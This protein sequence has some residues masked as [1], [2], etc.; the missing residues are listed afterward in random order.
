MP[1]E[2]IPAG[3]ILDFERSRV[4]AITGATPA[5][6]SML[7]P[8]SGVVV[9]PASAGT[10]SIPSLEPILEVPTRVLSSKNRGQPAVGSK[11]VKSDTTLRDYSFSEP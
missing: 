3:V 7:R 1:A 11:V 5:S 10:V 4:V 2:K 6:A 9:V 8:T